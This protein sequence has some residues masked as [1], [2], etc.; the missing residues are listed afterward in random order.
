MIFGARY[1]YRLCKNVAGSVTE[2]CFQK[3]HLDFVGDSSWLMVWEGHG[4]KQVAETGTTGPTAAVEASP[5]MFPVGSIGNGTCGDSGHQANGDCNVDPKGWYV[6][7]T[8][9][10]DCAAKVEGCT[11]ASYISWG[12]TDNSCSWYAECNFTELCKDCSKDTGPSCDTRCSHYY[13]FTSKVLRATPPPP[14]NLRRVAVRHQIPRVTVSQGTTPAGSQWARVP[15]PACQYTG[16][17]EGWPNCHGDCAGCCANPSMAPA[18]AHPRIN[19]SWWRAQDCVAGCAG[20]GLPGSC[21]AGEVQFPEPIPG[22]SSL[23][24]SWLWCDAP[25]V[26]GEVA[27][28]RPTQGAH[29]GVSDT[30]HDMP[31]SRTNPMMQTNIVDR[32]MV[33][34]ILEPGEYLLSWRWDCEQ[35]DQIWQNCADVTITA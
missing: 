4:P 32:V 27:V 35:T 5:Q 18:P 22:M 6:G 15:I 33:P 16:E 20:N 9:L 13:A 23:W 10:A 21:P 19:A 30:P 17:K 12:A 2:E 11:Q 26:A 7:V 8:S 34:A 1:A 28:F 14:P 3:G 25:R 31:C 24:S 29:T